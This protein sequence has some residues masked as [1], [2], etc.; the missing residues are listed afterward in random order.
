MT[1]Q[2]VRELVPKDILIFNWFWSAEEKG[3]INEV[4]LEEFGFRQVYGNMEPDIHHYVARSQRPSILGGAPSSWAAT[5]EFNMNK[6]LLYSILGSSEML[7]S[8]RASDRHNLCVLTQNLASQPHSGSTGLRPPSMVGDPVVP[9]EISASFNRPLRDPL[10][11]RDLRGIKSGRIRA[12]KRVFALHP[13]AS[14]GANAVIA[15]GTEGSKPN[16]LP[17]EVRGIKIGE[18][19]T[20]LVFLHACARPAANRKAYRLIWDPDDSA[21][22]LGWYEMV[23]EDG[24][25][26][27]APIRYGINILEW[28]WGASEPAGKY[29]YNAEAVDCGKAGSFVTLFAYEWAS[30]RLGKVVS[31]VHLKGSTHFRGA[32]PG[33]ENRFGDVISSNAIV[34]KAISYVPRR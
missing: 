32:V 27:I 24:L 31:E 2:Q 11:G 16:P 22:L 23:Y 12:G 18:D 19:V 17:R 33:F 10:F 21:D 28:S 29:C 15:V 6:D 8:G 14:P 9:I 1:P 20:S 3:E 13:A 4:Q 26:E 30:P 25:A 5:T 34:L 7:W